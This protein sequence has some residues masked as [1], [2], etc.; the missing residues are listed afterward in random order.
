MIPSSLQIPELD[1]I[2]AISTSGKFSCNVSL[3]TSSPAALSFLLLQTDYIIL[4]SSLPYHWHIYLFVLSSGGVPIL[5]FLLLLF[6]FFF[7]FSYI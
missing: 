6:D 5:Y 2:Y 3:I 4:L 1:D 7:N